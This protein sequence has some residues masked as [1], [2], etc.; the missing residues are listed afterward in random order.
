MNEVL[1]CLEERR[2]VRKFKAE[3]IKDS[4]LEQILEAGIYAPTGMG[5]QSPIIVAVQDA[6]TI[7]KLSKMNAA[8][9]GASGDP[10]YGA[11]TVLVVLAD[12]SRPTFVEDGALVLG[13]MMNAAF[14]IGVDSCWIHRAHEVFDTE[15]GKALLKQWG[16]EGDYQGIG[17]CILGYRDGELPQAK[18]R[19][20]NY[21]Y[22]V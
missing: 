15:E 7:E 8:V 6:P 18:P 19:K 3:Q 10:F 22:R 17:H 13:N 16:I 4:E 21:I 9:M 20:E 12:R 2:S 11:P 5:A 14:S 1:K